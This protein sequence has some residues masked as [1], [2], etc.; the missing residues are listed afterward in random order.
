MASTEPKTS[1]KTQSSI[2]IF[3]IAFITLATYFLAG[4]FELS[5]RWLSWTT[6]NE[7]Y[8]LDELVFVFI[9]LSFCL[10]LFSRRRYKEL[11]VSLDHNI[12]ISKHLEHKHTEIETLLRQNRELI[13]HIT[14][15]REKERNELAGELHDVFG[16]YLAAI[17]VNAAVASQYTKGDERLNP[18]LKTIQS[19]ASHLIEV[20]RSQLRSIKPPNLESV[21]LS[22]SIDSLVSQ[23]RVSFPSYH[24]IISIDVDDEL[25]NYDTGL[26]IYRCLQEGLSNIVK[27]AGATSISIALFTH[28]NELSLNEI[29][30]VILDDG[31]GLPANEDAYTGIGIIGMRE[32]INALSGDFS[33]SSTH[34][35]GT[36]I[37]I[38]APLTQPTQHTKVSTL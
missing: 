34:P 16:Q 12:S 2:E 14:Q 25:V 15:V 27:H 24:L 20:T 23:W 26:S 28:K 19:S 36:E 7:S 31:L 18:I 21:G 38:K 32:R 37:K 29:V 8:Q 33:I 6:P 1:N 13:N 10:M 9:T 30:L 5:E 22:A 4:Y 17:D 3:L 11:K 35:Q